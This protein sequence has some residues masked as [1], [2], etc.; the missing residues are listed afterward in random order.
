MDAMS[1]NF[2]IFIGSCRSVS[3]GNL[4][5]EFLP[6]DPKAKVRSEI[7]VEEDQLNGILHVSKPLRMPTLIAEETRLTIYRGYAGVELFGLKSDPPESHNQQDNNTLRAP[8]TERLA[9]AIKGSDDISPK[10]T[11]FA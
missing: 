2:N 5:F 7:L 3:E 6:A 11:F 10:P 9:R 1:H 4:F 8:M